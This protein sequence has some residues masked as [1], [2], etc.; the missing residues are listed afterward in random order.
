MHFLIILKMIGPNCFSVRFYTDPCLLAT[1]P[2]ASMSVS[3]KADP[4]PYKYK[5]F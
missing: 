2:G 4:P 1:D 5:G 3:G